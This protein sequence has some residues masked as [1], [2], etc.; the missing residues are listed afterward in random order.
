MKV[1]EKIDDPRLLGQRL[2][3]AFD[4]Y[5]AGEQI[6]RQNLKRRY[7]DADPEELERH[8]VDW[9]CKRPGAEHGDAV[10]KPVPWPRKA[11]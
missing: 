5:E 9:L 4:L 8:L 11:S 6:M 3:L 1:M 10:G 7:P 2:R